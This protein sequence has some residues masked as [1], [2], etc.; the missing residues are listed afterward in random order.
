[1]ETAFFKAKACNTRTHTAGAAAHRHFLAHVEPEWK[2]SVTPGIELCGNTYY[3]TAMIA[4]RSSITQ[5]TLEMYYVFMWK[6]Q[7]YCRL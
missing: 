6:Y 4:L 2:H 7:Q 3:M 1:M 5:L